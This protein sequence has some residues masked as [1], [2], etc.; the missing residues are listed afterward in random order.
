MALIKRDPTPV[1]QSAVVAEQT[2][3]AEFETEGAPVAHEEDAPWEATARPVSQALAQRPSSQEVAQVRPSASPSLLKGAEEEGFEG[4]GFDFTSFPTISLKTEGNF[5]DIDNVDYGKEFYCR[6][7]GSKVRYVYR[8]NPYS[9]N[10][11]DVAFSYDRV[12]TQN[13]VQLDDK[14]REWEAQ[15]KTWEERVYLEAM[16]EMVGEGEAYDG[17]Y[18]ILS[19][20][21]TSKGRFTSVYARAKVL[22]NGDATKPVIKVFT[23]KVTKVA[24]P[25][26][27]WQFEVVKD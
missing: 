17:E 6:L 9:D 13:G 20:S 3:Q 8:A 2:Y 15:G 7:L 27:S 14:F 23:S 16:V 12:T 19:I 5:V 1:Q 10:K 24:Q 25:F 26:W 21:P 18:R 11:R 4:L 22:G